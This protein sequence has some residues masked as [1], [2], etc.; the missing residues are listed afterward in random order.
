V[1][2]AP[3]ADRFHELRKRVKYHWYH[4]RLLRPLW[5]LLIRREAKA[6]DE[7][8]DLLGDEHDL[9][10]F[11]GMLLREPHLLAG[12]ELQ[13]ELF[14]CIDRRRESLRREAIV[15]SRRLFAEKP[16]HFVRRYQRYWKVIAGPRAAN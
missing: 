4:T 9:S 14:A 3:E 12:V 7:L 15:L 8:S 13:A 1:R 6:G 11:R 16:K 2:S 10:V 5:P